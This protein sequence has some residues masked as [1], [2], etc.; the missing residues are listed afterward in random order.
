MPYDARD[1]LMA[2]PRYPAHWKA[3]SWL[4]RVKRA[5]GQCE[6]TGE[7]GLHQTTPPVPRRC[8][9]LDGMPAR[10]AKGLVRLT[11]AHL[12][13]TG[14]PCQCQPLCAIETHVKAMCN[15]CHLR[16]DVKLH[17]R[18]AWLGRRRNNLELFA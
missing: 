11:V 3:F 1:A 18:N 8:I 15:R 5:D 14:G 12:N 7:C 4:I 9:E 13:A 10:W 17:V 16:Y 6:C 2:D